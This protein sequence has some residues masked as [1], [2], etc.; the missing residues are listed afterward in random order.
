[1]SRIGK[2]PI[3][4]PSGVEVTIAGNR[5]A[6]AGPQGRV[7]REIPAGITVTREEDRLQVARAGGDRKARAFHGL[8]RALL[9]SAVTG[10]SEG[11]EKRLD[12]VGVSYQARLDGRKLVLQVG[13]ANLVTREIPEGVSVEVPTPTTIVVRGA[14]AQKVGQFAAEVRGVRPPEP[15]KGKGIRYQGERVVRKQG[16]SFVS[17]E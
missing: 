8:V 12:V 4:I 15:Y 9:E 16:K 10:V 14:D 17:T 2:R 5:V 11:F 1:M 7:E 6:V 13:F 3:P